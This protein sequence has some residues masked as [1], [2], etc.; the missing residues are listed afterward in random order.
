MPHDP[1]RTRAAAI[2]IGA[3]IAAT[4]VFALGVYLLIEATRPESGLVSF[5]FL[6]VLP[7]AVC[8][9]IAY[10]ADPWKE[11]SHRAY[12]RVPVWTLLAVVL[13]S[14]VFLREGVICILMLSPLWIVSGLIGAEITWRLRRRVQDGRTYSLAILALPLV[15]MQV[16]PYIPLPSETVTVARS[17]TVNAAP[18]AIW[19]MLRG[20]AD[21]RPGEGRWNVTQDVIGIPRP[22]G[23]R[24]NRDGLGADRHAVW[25]HGIRFRERITEW[26]RFRR[27]GWR[28]QFDD[29]EGW[30]YTDRH[31]MPDSAYFR[32]TTG[33]YR[34][35]PLPDGRTR[36]T[37]ETRYRVTTPVNA[38]SKLWG[39]L[40]LGDV[41]RNLLG[42][43]RD[44]AEARPNRP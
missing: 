18:E 44:R 17:I 25:Q 8:A 16:E 33:G 40:L 22:I 15:A 3:A 24:L 23:A 36:L 31:L 32:I 38:Y 2:R 37:L 27:I 5:S 10:V 1:I 9:V 12:L 29:I 26:E 39:E 13:L 41:E 30:G 34:M 35:A 6:L 7:A 43:I 42:I 28:F 4:L 14:L 21:V 11:R 20:I 19:P